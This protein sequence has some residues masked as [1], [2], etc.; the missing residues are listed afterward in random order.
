[1]SDASQGPGWWLANDGKW[2]PP[3][4]N[5]I[6]QLHQAS[7]A[8]ETS[9][10]TAQGSSRIPPS[11]PADMDQRSRATGPS[12]VLGTPRRPWVV[13]VLTVITLGIYGLYW[14]YASFDETNAYSGQGIGG[15]VGLILAIFVGIVNIFLLPAEI[16]NLYSREREQRPVSA[17]T[18]FWILLPL[19]GWFVWVVKSQRAL[20][21]FWVDRGATA[22]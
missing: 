10:S 11:T 7:V 18:G 1:M 17:A 2:Y 14:Q 16:G 22:L 13:A 8:S 3:E 4:E 20:N 21:R 19:V 9:P 12:G 15:V 6:Y 5:P